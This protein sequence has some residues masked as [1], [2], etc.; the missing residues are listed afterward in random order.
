MDAVIS[1]T[2]VLMVLRPEVSGGEGCLA[3]KIDM[4]TVSTLLGI[5]FFFSL[6]LSNTC[7]AFL[8]FQPF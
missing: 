5:F 3:Y 8:W 7:A 6:F 4:F 1:V 2:Q